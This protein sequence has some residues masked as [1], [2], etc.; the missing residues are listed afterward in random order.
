MNKAPI[1]FDGLIPGTYGDRTSLYTEDEC[2]V[3]PG[4]YYCSGGKSEP[5]DECSAGYYCGGGA[6]V[7]G[8]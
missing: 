1:F 4:G 5:D 2:A 3:C 7:P 6:S 8:K